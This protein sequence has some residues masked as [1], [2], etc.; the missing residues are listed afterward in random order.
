MSGFVGMAPRSCTLATDKAGEGPE[1][2]E[3]YPPQPDSPSAK[4]NIGRIPDRIRADLLR[5]KRV[6][7]PATYRNLRKKTEGR[8]KTLR[9]APLFYLA[10]LRSDYSSDT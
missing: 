4:H 7:F 10:R 8:I 3:G 2:G 9:S 1:D 6:S 5:C